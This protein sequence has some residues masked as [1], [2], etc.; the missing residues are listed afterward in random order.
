[1]NRIFTLL[2][3]AS[4]AAVLVSCG[5][6][7]Q[8]VLVSNES[9]LARTNETVELSFAALQNGDDVLTADNAIVL[10]HLGKQVPCQVYTEKD[11]EQ[12]LVFQADVAGHSCVKYTVKAGE[13]EEFAIRA[14]SR[15][16]PE[17]VDD[18]AYENNL[19]AG[20][21]YGPALADPRTYGSDVWLKCT[22][23]LVIDDWFKKMD[24]HHNYGEGMD[25]YKVANTLGG[26]AA[27]PYCGDKIVIGDNWATQEHLCDG[28]VRT[29][30][31]F[32]YNAINV[33][34]KPVTAVREISLD[35]N[36]RFVKSTTWFN[37]EAESL[38]IVLGAIQHDVLH[39]A[40]G[41][42]WIAFTEVASDTKQPEIDGNISI[43]LVLSPEMVSEGTATLDGHA[44]IMTTATV[45]APVTVWTASGWS[46]G[47]VESP[48]A[49]EALVKDFAYAQANPLKV[50][51]VK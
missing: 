46:Q 37:A 41:E 33:D 44:V 22:D 28:P 15:H 2:A 10:N 9:D 3:A 34:G 31:Y 14:Y 11:G 8:N 45:G 5:N 20:R 18:Y 51:I 25:C 13:R 32:T 21:I 30:A 6:A 7:G 43:G 24:Y 49:W 38:P 48:E 40:D 35:A 17:R 23:R 1:M 26:G 50:E 36:T 19:V 42:N 16:V 12:V 47:G 4:A 39:R 29:K 27:A